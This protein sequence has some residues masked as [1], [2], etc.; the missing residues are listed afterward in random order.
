MNSE[1]SLWTYA[2]KTNVLWEQEFL[3]NKMTVFAN[4]CLGHF[5]FFFTED[6]ILT[7]YATTQPY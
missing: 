5:F 6:A 1:T 2:C 7:F 4:V 3:N